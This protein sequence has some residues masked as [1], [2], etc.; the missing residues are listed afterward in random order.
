M[1]NAFT[2]TGYAWMMDMLSRTSME[3]TE[4]ERNGVEWGELPIKG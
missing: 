2:V 1:K 4:T 3:G